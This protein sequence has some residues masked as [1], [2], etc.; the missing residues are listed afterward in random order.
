MRRRC[1]RRLIAV[2]AGGGMVDHLDPAVALEQFLKHR[3]PGGQVIVWQQAC[4]AGLAGLMF[5]S[6]AS[7]RAAESFGTAP[8]QAP[9]LKRST[10]G[11]SLPQCR[12]YREHPRP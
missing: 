8:P 6:T 12:I 3:S 9:A 7:L 10:S 1:G 5:A 4:V 11:R 2:D